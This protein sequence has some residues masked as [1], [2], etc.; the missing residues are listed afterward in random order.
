VEFGLLLTSG[1]DEA[2]SRSSGCS[3]TSPESH[4]KPFVRLLSAIVS[5][6]RRNLSIHPAYS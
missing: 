1:V 6:S 2:L 5:H 4:P 3:T